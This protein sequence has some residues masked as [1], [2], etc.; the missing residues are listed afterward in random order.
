MHFK[1]GSSSFKKPIYYLK[2]EI[3]CTCSPCRLLGVQNYSIFVELPIF[4]K[5]EGNGPV[6]PASSRAIEDKRVVH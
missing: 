2:S 3:K 1:M 4:E 5:L 6:E